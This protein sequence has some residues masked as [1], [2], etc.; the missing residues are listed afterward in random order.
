MKYLIENEKLELKYQFGKGAWTYHL[1]IPNTKHLVGKWG[2]LKVT[3]FIDDFEIESINLFTIAGQDKL[4]SINEK[5][6]KA[7]NKTGGEIVIVTL[8]IVNEKQ[9]ITENEILE[10]FKESNVFSTF[11]QLSIKEKKA[12]IKDIISSNSETNQVK[13]IERYINLNSEKA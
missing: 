2:S 11:D 9:T 6:R 10:I 5:I 4:I 8:Q 12:I 7:I 1:Q 13:L 3:G